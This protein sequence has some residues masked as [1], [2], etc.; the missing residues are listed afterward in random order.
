MTRTIKRLPYRFYYLP[1]VFLAVAGVLNAAYLSRSH[2]RNYTDPVYASF[3]AISQAINC[4]TVAQSPWSVMLGLPVAVWGLLGYLVFALLLVP[5]RKPFPAILP[6]W[7][8]MMVWS[9][10]YALLAVYFGYISASRINSHC[11]LCLLSHGTSLGLFYGTW[12]IRRRF[13]EASFSADVAA[14]LGHTSLLRWPLVA[15]SLLGIATVWLGSALP[16]YWKLSPPPLDPGIS[17]GLT[18]DGHAWIGAENPVLTITEFSDYMC[19]QCKKAHFMLRRLVQQYPEHIRLVHRHF[20]MD[21]V[22]NPLVTEPFHLG[23][24][25]MAIIALYA[26]A[27][28]RFWEVNDLLYELASRKEDFNTALIGER[29]GVPSGELAAAL[30]N[31]L[32]RLRLKHDIAVGIRDGV[33]G[34]PAFFIVNEL[35]QGTIPMD[36]IQQALGK[37]IQ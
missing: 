13:S 6:L 12:L 24:G 19:F 8:A 32:L 18:I 9:G 3:C 21:H 17:Q 35:Y 2:Y 34:T 29:I 27:R 5:L 25:Q 10:A 16:P 4:D 1:I 11:I 36:V 30:N 22:Y 7:S 23:A 15:V 28:D 26:Q 31:S 37:A 33:S 14:C 20:P